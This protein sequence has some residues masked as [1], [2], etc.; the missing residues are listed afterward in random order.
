MPLRF[1]LSLARAVLFATVFAAAG[2][3]ATREHQGYLVDNVLVA[4]VQPGID[5]K[6]S[7]QGTLGRPSFTGQFDQDDWYYVSRATKA[8]AFKMPRP[9]AQV[10]LHIRFDKS[11]NVASVDKAG[12]EQIVAL[13]PSGDKTPTL[14]HNKG[15]FE[16]LFGNIGQV[17]AAS[18]QAQTADNP[19]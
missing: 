4:S 19:Q 10:I 15:F 6:A 5:T 8:L 3:T 16:E 7:V 14:G 12:M 18:T 2:C 1:R 17:G 11:G 13:V 9:Y